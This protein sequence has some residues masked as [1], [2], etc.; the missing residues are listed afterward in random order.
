MNDK[1]KKILI[2]SSI[3]GGIGLFA[4]SFYYYF[5]RQTELAKNFTF[6]I[7]SFSFENF[8]LQLIK[9][10]LNILFQS[11][12]DLEIVVKEFYL[13]FYFNGVVVG[14]LEDVNEFIIPSNSNS[15]I[16]LEF[17][18]NPQ[19]IIKDIS[20]IVLY[21]TK[22]KDA[23][24]DIVGYATIKSGFITLTLPIEYSSTLKEMLAP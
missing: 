5:K 22:K 7:L 24:I 3:I 9:G 10:K 20:D 6:K 2:A 8:D 11:V 16:P 4:Y 19:L 14:Y 1:T 21:S 18:L 13:D 23:N 17:N 15:V 12:S